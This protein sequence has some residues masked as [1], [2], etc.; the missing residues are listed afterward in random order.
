MIMKINRINKFKLKKKKMKC[1]NFYKIII[2]FFIFKINLFLLIL[3]ESS[4]YFI[5]DKKIFI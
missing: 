4:I 1:L 2:N 5:I 3:V